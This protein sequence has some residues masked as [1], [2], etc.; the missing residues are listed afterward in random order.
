MYIR[1][2]IRWFFI[3]QCCQWSQDISLTWLEFIFYYFFFM[4]PEAM[5]AQGTLKSFLLDHNIRERDSL[6]LL[7]FSLQTQ[8]ICVLA[9]YYLDNGISSLIH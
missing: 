1:R 6:C 5:T 4:P 9:H 8:I 7:L 2:K 3:S